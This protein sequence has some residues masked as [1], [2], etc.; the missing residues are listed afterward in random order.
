MA[1]GL[2]Q[3]FRG[4][5]CRRDDRHVA[6]AAAEVAAEKFADIALARIWRPREIMI[7]RNK[8][9]G[10]AEAALQGVMAEECL[11][12]NREAILRRRQT[13]DGANFATFDLRREREAGAREPSVDLDGAS[14]AHPVLAA[15]MRAGQAQHVAQEIGEQH[16][17]LR[18]G[19]HRMAV[20]LGA[21]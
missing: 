3:S 5:E 2:T 20:D 7:E 11:L 6:G 17:G 19:L 13:L 21:N 8:D 15:D 14:T 18:L 10:G 16:A 4:V 9:A 12:Q 1:L